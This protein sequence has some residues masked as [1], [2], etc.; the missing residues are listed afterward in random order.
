MERVIFYRSNLNLIIRTRNNCSYIFLENLSKIEI[1]MMKDQ[2][3]I[4]NL[5]QI[6]CYNINVL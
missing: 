2:C 1:K 4:Y 6:S 3:K 5:L